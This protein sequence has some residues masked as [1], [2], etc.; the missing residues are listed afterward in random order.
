MFFWRLVTFSTFTPGPSS[1]SYMVT[2]G[3]RRNPITLASTLNCWKVPVRARITRSF[4]GVCAAWG[5]PFFSMPRSGRW[6]GP[7]TTGT[8]SDDSPASGSSTTSPVAASTMTSSPLDVPSA[9]MTDH[10]SAGAAPT[11]LIS[12][13]GVEAGIVPLGVPIG[14]DAK[15][16]AGCGI[17]TVPSDASES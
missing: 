14:S 17:G 16:R 5:V 11:G 4:S 12:S 3:P 10:G 2:E 8:V 13:D 15:E 6:Y 1:T 9:S 7:S